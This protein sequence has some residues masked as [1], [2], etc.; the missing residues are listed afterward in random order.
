MGDILTDA[1][2]NDLNVKDKSK[3]KK[4]EVAKVVTH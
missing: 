3:V 1:E 4:K 2:Y